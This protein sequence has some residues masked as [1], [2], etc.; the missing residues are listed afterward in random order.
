MY[1]LVIARIL[2]PINREKLLLNR[3]WTRKPQQRIRTT[4]LVVRSA[5]STPSKRLLSDECGGGFA[6]YIVSQI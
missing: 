5:G 2:I 3:P 4:G 6:V 1:D